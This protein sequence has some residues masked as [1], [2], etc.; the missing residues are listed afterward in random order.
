[1]TDLKAWLTRALCDCLEVENGAVKREIDLERTAGA[2]LALLADGNSGWKLVPVEP[3][4]EMI[5]AGFRRIFTHENFRDRWFVGTTTAHV[6]TYR[7]MLAAA[8]P[9]A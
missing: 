4:E 7:A 9:P 6:D 8:T 3:D 5:S 2:L 1:M